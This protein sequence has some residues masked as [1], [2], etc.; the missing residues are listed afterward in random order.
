MLTVRHYRFCLLFCCLTLIVGLEPASAQPAGNNVAMPANT[1]VVT[2]SFYV[3]GAIVAL[4]FAG[5]VYA[6][7]RS[8]RRV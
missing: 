2:R 8:S 6:V 1:T 5:A 3:E 7:G 4:L